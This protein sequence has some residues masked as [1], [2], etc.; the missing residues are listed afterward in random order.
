[1]L[2]DRW[3]KCSRHRQ[4]HDFELDLRALQL[5]KSTLKNARIS[6]AAHARVDDVP[7][8][9]SLGQDA[10]F[11]AVLGHVED[12]IEYLQIGEADISAL[13]RQALGNL[14]ELRFADLHVETVAVISALHN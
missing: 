2:N 10:P 5:L 1:M 4:R 9:E 7:A 12:G 6:P 13:T 11:G 3:W 14:F 8:A